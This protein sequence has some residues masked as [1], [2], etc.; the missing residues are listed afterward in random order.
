MTA[1]TPPGMATPIMSPLPITAVGEA[2]TTT[3]IPWGCTIITII[4]TTIIDT[5]ESRSS[6]H[7]RGRK[8]RFSISL[9]VAVTILFLLAGVADAGTKIKVHRDSIGVSSPTEENTVRVWGKPRSV[10]G[11]HPIKVTVCNTTGEISK[12]VIAEENGSFSVKIQGYPKDKLKIIF[13]T[14]NGK[15]KTVKLKVPEPSMF[16]W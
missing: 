1:L 2:I 8:M 6:F 4:T 3:T 13:T 15:K 11:E 10:L 7:Q 14:A 16:P 9:S 12:E 5:M